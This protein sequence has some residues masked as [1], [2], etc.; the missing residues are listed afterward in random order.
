[1]R[2][3]FLDGLRWVSLFYGRPSVQIPESCVGGREGFNVPSAVRDSA[4]QYTIRQGK[5]TANQLSILEYAK[6][7]EHHSRYYV[8]V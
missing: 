6:T 3:A 7:E 8:V 2:W 4:W 1:M 5:A